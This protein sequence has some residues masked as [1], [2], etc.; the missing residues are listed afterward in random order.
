[1]CVNSF[2]VWTKEHKRLH[3]SPYLRVQVCFTEEVPFGGFGLS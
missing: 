2:C 3:V 1:M